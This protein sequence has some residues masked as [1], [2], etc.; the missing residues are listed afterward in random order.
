MR[1]SLTSWANRYVECPG[2]GVRYPMSLLYSE[3]HD[4]PG[5]GKTY[6]VRCSVCGYQFDVTFRRGWLR[7][8]RAIVR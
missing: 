8:L 4:R 1:I 6:T 5:D 2:C 3:P 7:S